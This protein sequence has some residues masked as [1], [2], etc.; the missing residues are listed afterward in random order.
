MM[1]ILIY[2]SCCNLLQQLITFFK[3]LLG[4]EYDQISFVMT[5]SHFFE[6][7]M[8]NKLL[9]VPKYRGGCRK[10]T[11][12]MFFF[13][14]CL[15]KLTECNF[16]KAAFIIK[17]VLLFL[18][19]FTYI[20]PHI[21]RCDTCLTRMSVTIKMKRGSFSPFGG[22]GVKNTWVIVAPPGLGAEF[23]PVGWRDV[24]CSAGNGSSCCPTRSWTPCTAFS[25]TLART[26]TAYRSIRPLPSTPTTSPTSASSDASS[27]WWARRQRSLYL[28][29]WQT[30]CGPHQWRG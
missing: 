5:F 14:F 2:S 3:Q 28:T 9:I 12:S 8:R 30:F 7:I 15:F 27:P 26:T 17:L 16:F 1:C 10:L 6:N 25:S 19:N 18:H 11:G 21:W 24:S 20:C 29:L 22:I 23:W 4:M 13:T